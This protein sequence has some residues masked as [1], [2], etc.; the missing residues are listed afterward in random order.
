MFPAKR[1]L[2]K[3][4]EMDGLGVCFGAGSEENIVMILCCCFS[5]VNVVVIMIMIT[6]MTMIFR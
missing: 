3:P 5:M 2:Y 1:V 6:M 4:E